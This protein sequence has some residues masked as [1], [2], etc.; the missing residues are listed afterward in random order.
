[1]T[2]TRKCYTVKDV[3]ERTGIYPQH[4][5]RLTHNNTLNFEEGEFV[6]KEGSIVIYSD[7]A[8]EKFMKYSQEN[9]RG[10]KKKKIES[11]ES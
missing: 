6:K 10:R 5:R 4:I 2:D 7:T 8:L 3:S 1:M 11:E 9:H